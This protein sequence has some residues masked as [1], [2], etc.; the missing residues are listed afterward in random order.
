MYTYN[1]HWGSSLVASRG[2]AERLP[3][4]HFFFPLFLVR[5]FLSIHLFIHSSVFLLLS[6]SLCHSVAPIVPKVRTEGRRPLWKKEGF[7]PLFLSLSFAFFL[8]SVFP[9]FI[10]SGPLSSLV[11][12]PTLWCVWG[13]G[14]RGRWG[15]W[16]EGVEIHERVHVGM[17]KVDE[18]EE[19]VTKWHADMDNLFRLIEWQRR[20][21]QRSLSMFTLNTVCTPVGYTE[22]LRGGNVQ[23][24]QRRRN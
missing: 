22:C 15:L 19:K 13:T 5:P 12:C 2:R 9:R 18:G 3:G 14:E 11:E 4:A 10:P 23:R 1:P 16:L 21:V 6:L 17:K 24:K 8:E 7:Y 20:E